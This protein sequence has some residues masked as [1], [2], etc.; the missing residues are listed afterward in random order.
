MCLSPLMCRH[1]GSLHLW[2]LMD[3]WTLGLLHVL[4]VKC[5]ETLDF[6]TTHKHKKFTLEEIKIYQEVQIFLWESMDQRKTGIR[7]QKFRWTPQESF[8]NLWSQKRSIFCFGN[9]L[10]THLSKAKLSTAATDIM[11]G[12]EKALR[13]CSIAYS[14]CLKR[15]TG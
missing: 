1:L 7:K 9:Y 2:S 5:D 14:D 12:G 4:S 13:K 8:C 11:E 3:H 10:K 6:M 15:L